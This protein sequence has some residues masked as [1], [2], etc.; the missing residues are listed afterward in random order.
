MTD[1]R[2]CCCC[3]CCC[4]NRS[5]CCS[6]LQ[7]KCCHIVLKGRE[8]KKVRLNPAWD[9][10]EQTEQGGCLN[11]GWSRLTRSCFPLWPWWGRVQSCSGTH[12]RNYFLSADASHLPAP[13]LQRGPAINPQTD[14][15]YSYHYREEKNK[16][17]TTKIIMIIR[18]YIYIFIYIYMYINIYI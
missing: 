13:S 14:N 8:S 12:W 9:A 15:I 6:P 2:G 4:G 5:C 17:K 10:Q 16:N 11:L 3:C 7:S 18:L 1:D